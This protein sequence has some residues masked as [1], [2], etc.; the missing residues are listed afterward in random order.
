MRSAR[1]TDLTVGKGSGA[2][3]AFQT[4]IIYLQIIYLVSLPLV[5]IPLY[6]FI[7]LFIFV[8]VLTRPPV[9]C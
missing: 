1:N 9:Q 8:K 2:V 6:L 3:L 4:K 5:F 7:Y